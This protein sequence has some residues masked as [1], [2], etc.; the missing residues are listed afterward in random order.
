[1]ILKK[2]WYRYKCDQEALLVLQPQLF[3]IKRL[4][5]ISHGIN[6]IQGLQGMKKVFIDNIND[7]VENLFEHALKW[8]SFIKDFNMGD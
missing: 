8:A 3:T 2:E 1:M 5:Y 4:F 7:V 6:H